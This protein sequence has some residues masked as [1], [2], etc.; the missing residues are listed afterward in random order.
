MKERKTLPRHAR[1]K[2][3]RSERD[4]IKSA[5]KADDMLDQGKSDR[6]DHQIDQDLRAL[7]TRVEAEPISDDLKRLA[8]QLEERLKKRDED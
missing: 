1:S 3:P 5:A 6:D 2:Q 4:W 7:H 8:K